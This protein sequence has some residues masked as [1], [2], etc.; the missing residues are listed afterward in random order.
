[1]TNFMRRKFS[2]S[3]LIYTRYGGPDFMGLMHC[4]ECQSQVSSSADLCPHCGYPI[5]KLKS[6]SAAIQEKNLTLVSDL[7]RFGADIDAKDD[8]DRTPLMLAAAKGNLGMVRMLLDAGADAAYVS[9]SG[10]TALTIAKK[11]RKKDIEKILRGS[12]V[13]RYGLPQTDAQ[14][15]ETE[16]QE[17]SS[18]VAEGELR[19]EN[20]YDLFAAHPELASELED[21]LARLSAKHDSPES[22]ESPVP[23]DSSKPDPPKV[24]E[25]KPPREYQEP[26]LEETW[27]LHIKP[28]ESIKL[29]ATNPVEDEISR[30]EPKESDPVP[31]FEPVATQLKD[32]EPEIDSL[33]C[34]ECGAPISADDIQCYSCKALIVRRYC[35][36]CSKLVPEHA[37][38]CPF[39]GTSSMTHFHYSRNLETKLGIVAVLIAGGLLFFALFSRERV[40]QDISARVH[41]PTANAHQESQ[42]AVR[43]ARTDLKNNDAAAAKGS[44]GAS[45]SSGTSSESS[46]GNDRSLKD[47]EVTSD[48]NPPPS[49]ETENQVSKT[50]P[51]HSVDE[52]NSQASADTQKNLVKKA[53]NLN[54]QGYALMKSGKVEEAIPLLR[55]SVNSFPP[56]ARDIYYGYALFNLAQAFRLT[57]RPDLAIPLLEQSA[58]FGNQRELVLRELEAAK[59]EAANTDPVHFE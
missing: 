54:N 27:P 52:G 18:I 10:E 25:A 26:D 31:R 40:A 7:I 50:V 22:D 56:G 44:I 43:S 2:N 45:T 29:I 15:V 58:K 24:V 34:L 35:S 11:K 57:G 6:L 16:S 51:N 28:P 46:T 41:S 59:K 21:H 17:K 4:P 9:G 14:S 13:S 3:F 47:A 32:V 20:R 55:E 12:L 23:R 49:V 42:P 38:V 19:Q 8:H 48:D 36:H 53:H 39:C 1:M 37:G 5:S 30:I 33:N